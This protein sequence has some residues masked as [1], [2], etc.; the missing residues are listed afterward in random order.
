MNFRQVHLD[1]HTSECI[2]GIGERFDKKQFQDALKRGHVNSITVFSKCH[3]GW[4]YHPSEAN[5]MHPG[6]KFDLLQA[7]I[8]AA[9]E[10]DV[11]TPVYISAGFD[12]KYVRQHPEHRVE[13]KKHAF[14][15]FATPG[16]HLL[17][18]NTPYLD[19]LLEQVKE[20]LLRYDGDGIF[21]D[22]VGVRPC[23]CPA[24]MKSI[25]ARG[26]DPN[27]DRAIV[28]QAEITYKNYYERINALV[29]EIKPGTPV[30]QNA[31]HIR[32]GRRDLAY[33]NT[34][35]EI[36]SLPTGGWGYD[37]FPLAAKYSQN[38]GLEYLGMTG[39]FHTSWGEF[40]GYKHPNALRY[41][42]AL[43]AAMG[44]KCS[45]GDQLHPSGF[46]DM[47]TYGIIGEA[48]AELEK[49]EPFCEGTK[50]VCDVALFTLEAY[51]NIA[52]SETN[53]IDTASTDAGASRILLEG[54]YQFSVVDMDCDLSGY[55]VVILPDAIEY[56]EKLYEK[57][58][59]YVKGGGKI[60]ASGRS[61]I[62]DGKFAFDLGGTYMGKSEFT[63]AYARLTDDENETDYIMYTDHAV[64]EPDKDAQIIAH[65]VKPYFNRTAAHFCSHRHTPSSSVIEGAAATVGKDGAYI[66]FEIFDDYAT[67]GELFAKTLVCKVLDALLGED[68]LLS[69]NLGSMGVC[70]L[71][72]RDEGYVC[73]LLYAIPT[74]RGVDIEIIEDVYPVH[75]VEVTLR[76][77][78]RV[79]RVYLAPEGV[80][81]PFD[82][83]DGGISIKN[84]TVDCARVIAIDV[85]K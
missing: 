72:E 68:K 85:E 47:T 62:A 45:I 52:I 35:L 79:K 36:E 25:M 2:D 53:G 38:L 29:N 9:H 69:T 23:C 37:H 80:D 18:M 39:K 49:I 76:I 24:C 60:L 41:E 55:K 82:Q 20:V 26:K 61:A 16:Y 7:Q 15:N 5:E 56:N 3:H 84:V 73:H 70:T 83:L 12:E 33:C 51:R 67:K 40:G 42:V 4:A 28:E 21:L 34:H 71:R 63:P 27:D 54:K 1:F 57:L 13:N 46:M 22:I 50:P 30:F 31:G 11:K 81:I 19:Y 17:C 66:A 75:N 6:L 65:A 77:P 74:K 59:E 58:G 8:E 43:S 44:A 14:D 32:H 64:V 78:E 10:I 48:Y